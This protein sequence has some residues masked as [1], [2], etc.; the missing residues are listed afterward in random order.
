MVEVLTFVDDDVVDWRTRASLQSNDQP[1]VQPSLRGCAC[2]L[3]FGPDLGE[4]GPEPLPT[5]GVEPD[6]TTEPFR[7]L[8]LLEGV[9]L[10]GVDDVFP[11]VEQEERAQFGVAGGLTGFRDPT[12]DGLAGRQVK[13]ADVQFIESLGVVVDAG[14][15]DAFA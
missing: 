5:F 2:G 8:V 14:D 15:F 4:D 12:R 9:Q 13:L 3:E 7:G 1:V 11:F 6:L 10:L